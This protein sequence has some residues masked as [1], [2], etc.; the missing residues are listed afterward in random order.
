M[1]TFFLLEMVHQ[2]LQIVWAIAFTRGHN[3][4]ESSINTVIKFIQMEDK[5]VKIDE[6]LFNWMKNCR[7]G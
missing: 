3:N 6:T 4:N 7:I 2:T 1:V 5:L